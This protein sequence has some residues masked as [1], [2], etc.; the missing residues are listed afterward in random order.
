[1]SFGVNEKGI[2]MKRRT[3]IILLMKL[4]ILSGIVIL[5]AS[6]RPALT[7]ISEAY[8]LS[9]STIDGG[10]GTVG[11]GEYLLGSTVGQVGNEALSGGDY[12][13]SGGF[14]SGVTSPGV[15]P[16]ERLFLPVIVK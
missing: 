8:E 1:M 7:Q 11:G 5:I 2:Q 10:G 9:W 14:M 4:L 16:M 3:M 13:L 12:D 6:V 15:A